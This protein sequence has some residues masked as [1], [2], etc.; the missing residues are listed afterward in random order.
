M[1]KPP[2]RHRT[3]TANLDRTTDRIARS[4]RVIVFGAADPLA[5]SVTRALIASGS[6]VTIAAYADEA[7]RS[8]GATRRVV[9]L[10]DPDAL[11]SAIADHDAVVSLEP[12]LGKPR[13]VLGTLLDRSARRRRAAKLSELSRAFADAPTTRWIQRSTAALYCDGGDRWLNEDWPTSANAA[14]EH[15]LRAEQ[16]ITDH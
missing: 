5:R 16:A 14:T 12:V 4:P 6:D 7:R 9:S 8:F 15:A 2:I 3:S 1:T 11:R 13:G 10:G